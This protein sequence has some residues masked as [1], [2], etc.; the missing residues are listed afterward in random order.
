VELRERRRDD[1]LAAVFTSDLRRAAETAAIAIRGSDLPVLQDWR[2]R[3]CD[4]GIGYGMPAAEL[5]AHRSRCLDRPY[6]AARAGGKRYIGWAAS[7]PTCRRAGV[8]RSSAT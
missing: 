5:H 7:S 4:H 8:S 3:E 1:G 2:L 6:P